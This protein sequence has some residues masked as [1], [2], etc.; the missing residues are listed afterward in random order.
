MPLSHNQLKVSAFC[1]LIGLMLSNPAFGQDKLPA[2]R[3]FDPTAIMVPEGYQVEAYA[4]HLDYPVDITFSDSGDVFVALAGGHTYGTSPKMAP[5]ARIVQLMPDGTQKIIY[6][7]MVPM[8]EIRRSDSSEAMPEGL[9]PPLTGVT[10]HQGKLYVSHRSRYSVL[11][12][13]T[14][15]FKTIVN[16]LPCW[17]EFLNAKPIFDADGQMVFFVSTQGNSG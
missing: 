11:D 3:T 8:K 10:W 6:D 17:G 2:V 15:E 5:P 1:A 12:P 7:K 13:D 4:T 16:G 9:I 14:G